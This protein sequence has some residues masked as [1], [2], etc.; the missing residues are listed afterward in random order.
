MNILYY[1]RDSSSYMDSWQKVH[2][3][4][5]LRRM[6]HS[7]TIFN[8]LDYNCL[9]QANEQ[10]VVRLKSKNWSLF[11][12]AH[13]EDL[14]FPE[15]MEQIKALGVP[16][17]LICFDN[18]HAPFMH[19]AI[20]PF[21]DLVW[22]TSFETQAMF[23]HWGCNCYFQ[24]YAANPYTF[25][26]SFGEE[27]KTIGFIG[28][29][30]GTRIEKIN[31]LVRA[32]INC[33]I[34]SDKINTTGVMPKKK[35]N[36]Q[37]YWSFFC[38]DMDLM[39]F[40]IGRKV[41]RAKWYKKILRRNSVLDVNSPYLTINTSVSFGEMNALYSNFSLCLGITELWDTYV[42][43]Y[44]VHKLHLRTFEIPMCGGLQF[45]SYT[46]ELANYFEDGKEIVF[47]SSKDEYIDKAKFYLDDRREGVRL[48][49][50]KAAR[51]R[52]EHE[53]T[54]QKRFE[55]IFNVMKIK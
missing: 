19:Q 46:N 9:I 33:T 54:W 31:D 37:D 23:E 36:V 10:L 14:L 11:M 39:R 34:Y 29:P 22:L 27:M 42:L 55:R 6:G 1:Y 20:A 7:I 41:L 2:F 32:N 44:P 25:Y 13:G 30:Y 16:S 21:F 28:T 52:S 47:Y 15:T 3:F 4:D 51:Y 8:Y 38:L 35:K 45:V 5:E 17:L 53:H 12:T 50:K 26:P 18:L 43:S 48:K 24:P 49:M 40:S